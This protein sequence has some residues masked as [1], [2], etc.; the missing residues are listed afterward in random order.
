MPGSTTL[1]PIVLGII[2]LVM[3]LVMLAL[4]GPIIKLFV[5]A[6]V[7]GAPVPFAALLGM[8]L[9]KVNARAVVF[10]HIRL[11]RAGIGV[12]VDQIETH[13]LAGGEV[14]AVTSLLIAAHSM[15]I[16]LPWDVATLFDIA[17]P[18][19]LKSHFDA[20]P[21][22]SSAKPLSMVAVEERMIGT[23]AVQVDAPLVAVRHED[24]AL[25]NPIEAGELLPGD[26]LLVL[27]A[28]ARV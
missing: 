18:G 9:R 6:N 27:S 4:L 25:L 24:G 23:P 17:R 10:S 11:A 28:S 26:T 19:V 3:A 7:A 1:P 20:Q 13:N 5:Q 15:G 2:V 14:A 22:H 16:A 8:W 12:S 21:K